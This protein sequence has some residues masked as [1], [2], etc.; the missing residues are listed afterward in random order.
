MV[1]A[2]TARSYR[3]V[4]PEVWESVLWHLAQGVTLRQLCGHP[5][6]YTPPGGE[7]KWPDRV[8]IWR[9]AQADPERKAAYDEA[10]RI[11]AGAIDE[12]CQEISDEADDKSQAAV[13]KAA[14]RVKVRQWRAAHLDRERF[15]EFKQVEH[16]GERRSLN[17]TVHAKPEDVA[18]LPGPGPR[19]LNPAQ[20]PQLPSGGA[21]SG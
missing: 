5:D 19:L 2:T 6:E 11:G 20:P 14:L 10:A 8:S 3:K 4:T 1:N 9:Y 21:T 13:A 15:G 18:A 16:S 17:I 7:S 12:E